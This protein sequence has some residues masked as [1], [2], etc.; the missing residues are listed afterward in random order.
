MGILK[1]VEQKEVW[2]IEVKTEK[3]STVQR[4]ESVKAGCKVCTGILKGRESS[5]CRKF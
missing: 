3:N 1:F 5:R 4:R 2:I